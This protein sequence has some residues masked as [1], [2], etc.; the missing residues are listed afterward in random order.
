MKK[1]L[2]LLLALLMLGS[3][4]ACN[5]EPVE[6]EPDTQEDTTADTAGETLETEAETE[7]G[8]EILRHSRFAQAKKA[9][10]I[11]HLG[12]AGDGTSQRILGATMQGLAAKLSDVQVFFDGGSIDKMTEQIERVWGVPVE[13]TMNGEDASVETMLRYYFDNGVLNQYVLCSST[14]EEAFY[15]A[16]SLSGVLN[17]VVATE[18]TKAL[19]DGIGYTCAIDVTDKTDAWLRQSEY[20]DLFN[21]EVAFEQ[22]WG[23]IPD[24]FD[25]CVL[26]GSYINYYNGYVADEHIAIYEFLDDNAVVF[27]WNGTLG[28]MPTTQSLASGNITLIP[29]DFAANLST[30]SGFR[31]ESAQQKRNYDDGTDVEDVH[32]VTF[33]YTDGDNI[34]YIINAMQGGGLYGSELRGTFDLGWGVPANMLETIPPMASYLYESMTERD[35]FVVAL[36]SIG[37]TFPSRWSKEARA[38]MTEDVADYMKRTDLRYML[39]LD[40]MAWDEE[41]FADYTEHDGIDGIFYV[42]SDN[43]N[44]HVVWTNGKP[45]VGCRSGFTGGYDGDYNNILRFLQRK[46]LS[47]DVS[48]TRS[49]SMYYVGCWCT[50]VDVVSSMVEQLPD[51]V[52]VVTPSEF[53]DRM[54]ANCTPTEE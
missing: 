23:I 16:V 32:T 14:N 29:S 38:A 28:E 46:T 10:V 47:T 54:I 35:E 3:L 12:S 18:E 17:A 4:I 7:G 9:S 21:K 30:L 42:G 13:E 37:Y 31:M 6:T 36:G 48:K 15:V 45:A 22:T 24:L 26:N 2:S 19:L 27:G 8:T 34:Q 52:D 49:Y 25:Y 33:I 1:I 50:G 44:G 40:D 43:V 39:I 5:G 41:L 20:W 11:Y 51:N 53:M